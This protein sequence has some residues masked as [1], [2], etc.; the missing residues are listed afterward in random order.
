MLA[1]K[2]LLLILSVFLGYFLGYF[3]TET[4]YRLAKY[5][6]FKMTVWECRKCLSTHIT[7]V[8]STFISLLFHDWIMFIIGLFFAAMLFIGL[9]IDQKNKTIYIDE[10]K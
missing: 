4:K 6:V 7:W 10:E 5:D 8:T 3:F 1:I 2:F 9:Y